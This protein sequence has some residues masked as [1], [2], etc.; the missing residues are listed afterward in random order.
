MK[1]QTT[2]HASWETCIQVKKQQLELHIE[3]R[4]VQNWERST[5][6]LYILTLLVYLYTEY[7]MWNT[8]LDESQARIQIARK[9]INN[10]RY[11]DD[12]DLM[13]ESKAERN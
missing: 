12:T 11:V 4:L 1:Y 10:L 9:N 6:S 2:S 13:A 3:N 5:S 7:I 8:G